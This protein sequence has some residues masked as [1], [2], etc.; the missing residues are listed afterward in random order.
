MLSLIYVPVFLLA[1]S[2]IKF[3]Y[4]FFTPPTLPRN[5][6]T[7]PFY[8]SLLPFFFDVDQSITYKTYLEQALVAHG[9]VKLFFGGR[10]NIL[11]TRPSYISEVLKNEDVFQKA[12]NQVKIPHSVLAEYTGENVISAHGDSWRL[13]KGVVKP[14]LQRAFETDV[15]QRNARKLCELLRE[16]QRGR[17]AEEGVL[18]ADLLQRYALANL[19][20]V[21]L[22][23][24]FKVSKFMFSIL[25][26]DVRYT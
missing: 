25:N 17:I 21:V 5:I 18:V 24:D 14:G 11:V 23:S 12:G 20:E 13:Y 9:A 1:I 2:L 6:P 8:V 26:L 7:I 15:V 19:S 16:E 4:T 3:I 22:Q 10:W